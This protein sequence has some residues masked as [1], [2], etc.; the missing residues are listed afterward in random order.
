MEVIFHRCCLLYSNLR[1][2]YT[3]NKPMKETF[4]TNTPQ[5]PKEVDFHQARFERV[6]AEK[7][8]ALLVRYGLKGEKTPLQVA[9][10]EAERDDKD[11][12]RRRSTEFKLWQENLDTVVANIKEKIAS[13]DEHKDRKICLVILGGGMKVARSVGQSLALHELGLQDAFDT[14]IGVS[15]GAGPAVGFVEGRE[16]LEKVAS[17]YTEECGTKEFLDYKRVHK[18]IDPTV[19]ANTM[20]TGS[21]ALDEEKIKKSETQLY[22]LATDIQTDAVEFID[23]KTAS[24]DI[25]AACEAS[26][27]IPLFQKPVNVNGKLY[28][29]G[30]FSPF[31]LEEVIAQFSPTDILVL[32]STSFDY[33]NNLDYGVA[34]KAALWTLAQAGALGS[35]E[36]LH[37]A[38]KLIE[39]RVRL[40]KFFEQVSASTHVNIGVLWPPE[41]GVSNATVNADTLKAAMLDCAQATMKEFGVPYNEEAFRKIYI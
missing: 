29:D 7:N 2:C 22:V 16:G 23:V 19:I 36:K 21:K 30:A 28:I 34:Q 5:T 32:P 27:A 41:V 37:S 9:Q 12:E 15:A 35:I 13:P 6:A 26:A 33:E 8:K 39:T 17:M 20:R 4:P 24:P 10:D 31:P 1:I 25:T 40:R 11:Y 3:E 38:K 14:V 18:I